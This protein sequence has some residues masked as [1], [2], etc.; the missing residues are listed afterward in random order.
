MRLEIY[1]PKKEEKE[2]LIVRLALK[3]EY[4][5]I[6]VIAVDE[7]GKRITSGDLIYFNPNG[8]IE[9]AD[10]VNDSLG[11]Q[12]DGSGSILENS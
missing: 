3:E 2:E 9:R 10:C 7:D 1:E 8:T 11:F 5:N 4:G 12:L 6:V